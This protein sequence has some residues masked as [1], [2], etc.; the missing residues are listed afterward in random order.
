[1]ETLKLFV[2]NIAIHLDLDAFWVIWGMVGVIL[3]LVLC[4]CTE[5]IS[6]TYYNNTGIVPCISSMIFILIIS[7]FFG[8]MFLVFL[9]QNWKIEGWGGGGDC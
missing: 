2:D 5:F 7:P 9:M 3:F 8:P 4:F 1:M 6:Y